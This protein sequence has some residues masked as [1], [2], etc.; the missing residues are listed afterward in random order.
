MRVASAT[1]KKKSRS[2]ECTHPTGAGQDAAPF[3]TATITRRYL[4]R[5]WKEALQLNRSKSRSSNGSAGLLY[6]VRTNLSLALAIRGHCLKSPRC[7]EKVANSQD[8]TGQ[9]LCLYTSYL[10]S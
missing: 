1:A 6:T 2:N 5:A 10:A 7:F 9:S 3:S 8:L 4:F